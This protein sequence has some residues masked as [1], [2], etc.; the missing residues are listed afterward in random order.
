MHPL[1]YEEWAISE[2]LFASVAEQVRSHCYENDFDVQ[3][4]K[5][6]FKRRT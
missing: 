4:N 1:A 2:F 6:R 5:A 3:E